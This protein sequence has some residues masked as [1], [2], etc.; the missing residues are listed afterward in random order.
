[1]GFLFLPWYWIIILKSWI[2][3][4]IGVNYQNCGFVTNLL[5]HIHSLNFGI[6]L[7]HPLVNSCT[8]TL[9]LTCIRR[10]NGML[11]LLGYHC[12]VSFSPLSLPP[13]CPN[14]I[15]CFLS[16]SLSP[17]RCINLPVTKQLISNFLSWAAV[18]GNNKLRLNWIFLLVLL[19]HHSLKE[20]CEILTCES[21]LL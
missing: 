18:A 21:L 15:S 3:A 10:D 13:F 19:Q 17:Y 5:L 8:H 7:S 20:I 6:S 11:P 16:S 9:T 2:F 12:Y 4:D 1:M 14:C